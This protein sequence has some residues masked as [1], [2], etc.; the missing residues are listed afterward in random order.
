[1]K[2]LLAP[3]ALLTLAGAASASPF[4][5]EELV[6]EGD[7]LPGLAE[8]VLIIG[9]PSINSSGDWAIP[10]TSPNGPYPSRESGVLGNDGFRILPGFDPDGAESLTTLEYTTATMRNSGELAVAGYRLM[11]GAPAEIWL[12]DSVVADPSG[13]LFR[14]IT[15]LPD[16]TVI[17]SVGG[18]SL[19][20]ESDGEGAWTWSI[21][22][23]PGIEIPVGTLVLTSGNGRQSY[24][25]SASGREAWLGFIEPN[26]SRGEPSWSIAADDRFIVVDGEKSA[27]PGYDYRIG[28]SSIEMQEDGDLFFGV[29][30]EWSGTGPA[31]Y[32][33]GI[34][35]EDG[36]ALVTSFDYIEDLEGLGK[37]G[38]RGDQFRVTEQDDLLWVAQATVAPGPDDPFGVTRTALMYNDTVLAQTGDI[39]ADGAT[40]LGMTRL[41]MS[42]DGGWII[43]TFWVQDPVL[44]NVDAVYRIAVPTPGVL[45]LG[46]ITGLAAMRRRRPQLAG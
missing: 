46:V 1:M 17:A 41:A 29:G 18:A 14:R 12:G 27:I 9:V 38:V 39:L 37:W 34:F 10:V 21:V 36:S 31:Q 20:S 15:V 35:R 13:G 6:R 33:S 42:D 4:V 32:G 3:F 11:S 28:G 43:A 23:G 45:S 19:A 25:R 44:G 26:G 22:H 7:V 5:L 40:L 2:R 16:E 30:L 8:P 24:A